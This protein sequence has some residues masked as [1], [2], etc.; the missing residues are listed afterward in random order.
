MN[1]K[2]RGKPA[3]DSWLPLLNPLAKGIS[4]AEARRRGAS[5]HMRTIEI[6][7]ADAS[8]EATWVE[9]IVAFLDPPGVQETSSADILPPPPA[10]GSFNT[11]STE[12][13]VPPK[14]PT[15]TELR[16]G[17]FRQNLIAYSKAQK[18]VKLLSVTW[19]EFARS[20]VE[21]K[22]PRPE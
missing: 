17:L 5:L 1:K 15:E 14:V 11:W 7:P 6:C 18:A 2:Q 12:E 22:A 9:Q 21:G 16:K 13:K 20:I 10:C 8:S 3:A 19:Q 4:P